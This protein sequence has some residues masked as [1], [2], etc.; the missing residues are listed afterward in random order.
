MAIIKKTNDNKDVERK[1]F[2]TVGGNVNSYS[3]YG[4]PHGG[5]PKT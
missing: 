3:Q 2:H 4:K 1:C 5:S